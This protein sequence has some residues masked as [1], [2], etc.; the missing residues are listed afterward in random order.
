MKKEK[1][2]N[3]CINN[4]NM[5][6]AI[7]YICD[8]IEKKKIAYIVP[9]N[10]DMVVKIEKDEYLK[11]IVNEA[12]L[13][14]IDGKPLIWISKMYGNQIK[15]KIS[16]SDLIPKLCNVASKKGISIFIIGGAEGVAKKAKE[17][18]ENEIPGINIVGTYS[19]SFG[20]EKKDDEKRLINSIISDANPDIVIACFGCPKQEKW[21]YENYKKYDSIVS[22]CGGA[23]VDFLA[24][25]VKR[26][27]NWMSES[28]LEWLYRFFQEP[29]R[30][31]KRY[32]IDD[33]KIFKLI[34]KYK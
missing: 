18:L 20:F 9:I 19:P 5:D 34:W 29:K 11:K 16:G 27:P 15:E 1:L 31:F 33:L 13:T 30:L 22:I 26:A 4:I 28:G 14:L 24:G 3:T 10:V 12:D 21:V 2:L 32:F 17:N 7:D 6:E 23:T 8:C 25:N